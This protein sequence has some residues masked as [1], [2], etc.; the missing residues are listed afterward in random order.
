M[1]WYP[2]CPALDELP[3]SVGLPPWITAMLFLIG[4]LA[5]Q[6]ASAAAPGPPTPCDRELS[7]KDVADL[8]VGKAGINRYSMTSQVPGD[9]CEF[10][11]GGGPAFAFVDISVKESTPQTWKNLLMSTPHRPLPG[12]GDEAADL[13]THDSNVPNAI[14]TEVY[15]RKG[16]LICMV[17][18]HRSK[19]PA[20]E[21]LVVPASS[22]ARSRKLGALCGRLFAEQTGSLRGSGSPR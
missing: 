13:G 9:G 4:S 12:V 6:S 2:S 10:G 11:V 22:D 15:A 1:E 3:K 5:W 20:G 21:K 18:L 19:G 16:D 8:L 7:A 14:E 17:S